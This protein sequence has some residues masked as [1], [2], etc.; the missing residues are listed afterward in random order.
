MRST[1][2]RNIRQEA[3]SVSG[4]DLIECISSTVVGARTSVFITESKS[5]VCDEL[6]RHFFSKLVHS[7]DGRHLSPD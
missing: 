1:Y 6:S 5:F 2:G 4:L 7:V 3:K